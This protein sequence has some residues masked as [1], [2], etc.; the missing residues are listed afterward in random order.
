MSI[1]TAHAAFDPRKY[2]LRPRTGREVTPEATY[3][4]RREF[5][6]RA[7]LAGLGLL[8]ASAA[9]SRALA[10]A[11][12][13]SF[14]PRK[15]IAPHPL[16]AELFPAKTQ[17]ARY[18]AAAAGRPITGQ[19]FALT[20]NNFYE[21]STNKDAFK[22]ADPYQ[23]YPWTLEVAGLCAKPA[24]YDIDELLKLAPLEERVYRFRCVEAWSMVVPWTGYPL[25]ELLK[26]AEPK[27]EAK[28]VKFTSIERPK[29]LKGQR[30]SVWYRWPYYE[31][32]RMDEA[33]HPLALLTFGSYG[34]PLAKQQ[35]APLRVITPWKYGYKGPKAIVKIEFVTEQPKT[36]WNDAQP[37]EYGF[38]SNVNPA[39]PHPRWSQATERVLAPGDEQRIPTQYLNGYAEEVGGLYDGKEF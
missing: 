10:A 34:M 29:E 35:G 11:E 32:L 33:M 26:R 15:F 25:A 4:S 20:Y 2:W 30:E 22:Y 1:P 8:A 21:L 39:K 37:E 14:D 3:L 27:S 5:L 23:P 6:Q 19:D 28:F 12:G 31:G 18:T 17:S 36:F 9:G 13:S 7:G 16:N 24:K 38:Y